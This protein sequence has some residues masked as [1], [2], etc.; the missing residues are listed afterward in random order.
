MW[1]DKFKKEVSPAVK[2]FKEPIGENGEEKTAPTENPETEQSM[3]TMQLYAGDSGI[4]ASWY[5]KIL[6]EED[7]FIYHEMMTH[8]P[9]L[10]HKN[11]RKVL[12]LGGGDGGMLKE[13]LK[14]PVSSNSCKNV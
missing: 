1:E 9:M 10:S 5:G 7:N 3:T 14:Y 13:A 2:F 4:D 8:L 12:I 6:L 11:P